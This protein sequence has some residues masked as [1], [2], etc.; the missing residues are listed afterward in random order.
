MIPRFACLVLAGLI[1]PTAADPHAERLWTGKNGGTFRGAFI[2]TDKSTGKFKF[3]Q[4]AHNQGK[5]LLITPDS[6][7]D[8]DRAWLQLE[9]HPDNKAASQKPEQGDPSD[10]LADPNID[11]GSLRAVDEPDFQSKESDSAASAVSTFLLWWDQLD[12]LPIQNPGK[13]K[14]KAGQIH[15]RV[16]RLFRSNNKAGYSLTGTQRGIQNHFERDLE[17]I[18]TVRTLIDHDCSAE[19]LRR[20]TGG[21]KAT[22]LQVSIDEGTKRPG[23]HF[24]AL[25]HVEANGDLIFFSWGVRLQGQ[26]KILSENLRL[27]KATTSHFGHKYE[28]QILNRQD[29]PEWAVASRFLID[30]KANDGLLVVAPYRYKEKGQVIPAPPDP[31]MQPTPPRPPRA[32]STQKRF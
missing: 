26:L 2:G 31:V 7:S 6:L 15:S 18:A 5:S 29:L 9:L 32:P 19:N 30:P 25:S 16:S 21:L 12:Y 20:Y 4:F 13:P 10:F 23:R 24:L 11:R 22:L 27:P 14:F 28:L 17:G 8:T 3:Y 1:L